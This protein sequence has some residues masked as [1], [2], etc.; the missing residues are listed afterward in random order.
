M[1]S[2]GFFASLKKVWKDMDKPLLIATFLLVVI[3]AL[4][5]V[6]ASSRET[7]SR[8]DYSAYHFFFK[9]TLMI[10][11]AIV[12]SSF[13]LLVPTKYYHKLAK[14]LWWIIMI[15]LLVLLFTGDKDRG[16]INWIELGGFKFQ[17]SEFA[18]PILIA[19]LAILFEETCRK[20]NNRKDPYSLNFFFKWFACGILMPIIV[21]IQ[22]DL[23]TCLILLGISIIMF[24]SSP[25]NTKNKIRIIGILLCLLIIGI[26][27]IFLVRGYLF[28]KEQYSRFNFFNPCARYEDDG[29]QVCNGMIAINNGGFFGLGI[30]KSQQKYSYIP[31]PHTDSIFAII[32]EETGFLFGSIIIL[33]YMWMMFRIYRIC[34]KSNTIRGRYLAF[35]A[36]I[37]LV[38]HVILNLG[39]ILGILPLTGV[40]LPL[41]SYGGSFT[42]SFLCMISIVQLVHIE[43]KNKLIRLSDKM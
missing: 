8:Y 37:Y 10:L 11:I 22:G 2:E 14:I 13:I 21:F 34:R 33:I 26:L 12:A 25:I 40:P 5:I 36:L 41:L 28:T 24:C 30:S 31:D 3:G 15:L 19:A 17:P 42:I 4:S 35:G 6:C 20:G 32:V 27:G 9:Q 16:S 29:Y 38:I 39:G 18:K 1:L 23:G 7:I 43:T